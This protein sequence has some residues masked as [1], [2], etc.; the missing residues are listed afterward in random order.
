MLARLR[1]ASLENGPVHVVRE[2]F[3]GS[4]KGVNIF[5]HRSGGALILELEMISSQPDESDAHL[6]SD[7]RETV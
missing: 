6:Y 2:T 3:A 5:A 7:V 1:R 4:A